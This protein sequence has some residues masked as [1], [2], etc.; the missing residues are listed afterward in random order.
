MSLSQNN[1]DSMAVEERMCAAAYKL[2]YLACPNGQAW[3]LFTDITSDRLRWFLFPFLEPAKRTTPGTVY[4]ST[5]PTTQTEL[6]DAAASDANLTRTTGE[7]NHALLG[8]CLVV[9]AGL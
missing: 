1:I 8:R 2:G 3:D 4:C 9:W 6:A 5:T 7:S